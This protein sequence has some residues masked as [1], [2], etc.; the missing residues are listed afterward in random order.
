MIITVHKMKEYILKEDIRLITV[1]AKTFPTGVVPAYQTIERAIGN[2]NGRHFYG[3]SRGSQEGID[4][5]AAVIP[6][7]DEEQRLGFEGHVVNKGTYITER[8][9]NWRGRE[10]IIGETFQKMLA[11]PRLDRGSFCV[12]RY[13]DNDDV[14]CMVKIISA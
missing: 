6:V 4:Y 5:W 7:G 14:T 2:P 1:K 8:L 12:E 11:D 13:E 10:Y 9:A 3:L